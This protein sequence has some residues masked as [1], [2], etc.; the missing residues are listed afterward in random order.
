MTIHGKTIF[1]RASL[2]A[3]AFG[4]TL[5][6]ASTLHAEDAG[7]AGLRVYRD[8]ATGA[9]TAPP[10]TT[11]TADALS[12]DSARALETAPGDLVEESGASAAGGVTMHLQG[13]FRAEESATVDAD[14]S[15]HTHCGRATV[16]R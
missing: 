15:A 13:R 4:A 2:V 7:N 1:A 6:V 16:Q 11:G 8:P 3:A 10:K 12:T 9:F 14:G 5:L